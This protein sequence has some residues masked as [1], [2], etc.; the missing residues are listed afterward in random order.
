MLS[1]RAGE[2]A[3]AFGLAIGADDYLIKPFSAREVIARIETHLRLARRRQEIEGNRAKD[4]FMA[5]LGHELRNPLTPI[6][7]TLGLMR[8]RGRSL[9]RSAT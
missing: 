2:E 5:L 7:A 9:V 3:R 1:A 8:L 6:L 4:E